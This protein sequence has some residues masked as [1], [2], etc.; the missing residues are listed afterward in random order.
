[1]GT[2][3]LKT[4]SSVKNSG[5]TEKYRHFEFSMQQ[6]TPQ[7]NPSIY[8]DHTR[9]P[10]V[11]SSNQH[12]S[13]KIDDILNSSAISKRPSDHP[14]HQRMYERVPDSFE[15]LKL[16]KET[17]NTGSSSSSSVSSASSHCSS[18]SSLPSPYQSTGTGAGNLL[19]TEFLLSHANSFLTS[20]PF[21][22]IGNGQG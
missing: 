16:P 19:T 18:V 13:F 11:Y 6:D 14:S 22:S 21:M 12:C 5:P 3:L 4:P 2:Y 17:T 20:N 7:A 9:K 15:T 10:K 8:T 1:M